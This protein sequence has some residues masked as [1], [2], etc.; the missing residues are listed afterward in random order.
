M[1]GYDLT[2]HAASPPPAHGKEEANACEEGCVVSR[3]RPLLPII[4]A[5]LLGQVSHASVL[6]IFDATCASACAAHGRPWTEAQRAQLQKAVGPALDIEQLGPHPAWEGG[7]DPSG[8]LGRGHYDDDE[9]QYSNTC[10][11]AQ[12]AEWG[13]GTA[14]GARGGGQDVAGASACGARGA[15]WVDSTLAVTRCDW[16]W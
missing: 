8:C 12:R 11:L 7:E 10:R 6:T 1:G 4:Y 5:M 16:Y 9:P 14:L 13:G 2:A 15:I 3:A